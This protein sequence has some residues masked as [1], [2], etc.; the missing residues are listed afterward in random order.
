MDHNGNSLDNYHLGDVTITEDLTI[1]GD[2]NVTD[3]SATD[4]TIENLV[5]T[6]ST[7]SNKTI[8]GN[9]IFITRLLDLPTPAGNVITLAA[10]TSYTILGDLDLDG[11]R[12]VCAGICTITGTNALTSSLTSLALPSGEALI[13]TPYSF[14]LEH[15]TIKDVLNLREVFAINGSG[16]DADLNWHN[17]HI[18]DSLGD[19]G[20]IQNIHHFNATDCKFTCPNL[21]FDGTVESI[22]INEC[23]LT[24]PASFKVGALIQIAATC[25]IS[26]WFRM[27]QCEVNLLDLNQPY[28]I[29]FHASAT[30]PLEAFII[31][32][33]DF[34]DG[35]GTATALNATGL[36]P[37]SY[38]SYFKNNLGLTNTSV[39]GTAWM[40]GNATSTT[41]AVQGTFYKVAGT[42]TAGALNNKMAHTNNRLQNK[43]SR[44]RLYKATATVSFTSGNN[45]VI[46]VAFLDSVGGASNVPS[47]VISSTA[48]GGGKGEAVTIQYI[49]THTD[50]DYLE[51]VVANTTSTTDITVT[52]LSMMVTEFI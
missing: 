36:G 17:V 21:K 18:L 4:L 38:Y 6:D 30:I 42:T 9:S 24:N 10:N 11:N 41:V 20:T 19:G 3:L 50:A 26:K 31:E 37:T 45:N 14:A 23:E 5:V 13:T 2:L 27:T 52:E 29:D 15:I 1:G 33:T 49:F 16:N 51:V 28:G 22:N 43:T 34:I 32:D 7:T 47:T 12:L 40:V 46:E 44:A 25:T 35:A 8:I 39:N 48:S